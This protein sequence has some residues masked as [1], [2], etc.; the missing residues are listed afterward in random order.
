MVGIGTLGRLSMPAPLR[1]GAPLLTL[2]S[3]AVAILSSNY[4][5]AQNLHVGLVAGVS[6]DARHLGGRTNLAPSGWSLGATALFQPIY[7]IGIRSDLVYSSVQRRFLFSSTGGTDTARLDFSLLS[8]PLQLRF[9]FEKEGIAPYVYAGTTIGVVLMAID[10]DIG[11]EEN[12]ASGSYYNT[13]SATAD[14]GVGA[15]IPVAR[16]LGLTADLRGSWVLKGM[17]PRDL[18]AWSFDRIGLVT[19]LFYQIF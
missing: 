7:P 10:E 11:R 18:E 16:R 3:A 6:A 5:A 14:L 13:F 19:S 2:L 17:A 4:L 15:T 1:R 8:L 12:E 9:D